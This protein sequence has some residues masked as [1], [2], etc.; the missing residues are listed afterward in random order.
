MKNTDAR[1]TQRV[2]FKSPQSRKK[3]SVKRKSKQKDNKENDRLKLLQKAADIAESKHSAEDMDFLNKVME[4]T[5]FA[6]KTPSQ[7]ARGQ[8]ELM[9][10]FS[11]ESEQV[12]G[13]QGRQAQLFE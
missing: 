3:K 5:K 2:T 7:E 11:K 4:E 1:G 12:Y 9:R 6:P 8:A 10:M 13:T